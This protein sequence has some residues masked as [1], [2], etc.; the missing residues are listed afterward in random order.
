[1]FFQGAGVCH[2]TLAPYEALLLRNKDAFKK[3][4]VVRDILVEI[5]AKSENTLRERREILKR[6]TEFSDYSV[7]WENDQ[8]AARGLVSQI[9]ELINVKD[10]FTRLDIERKKERQ[11]KIEVAERIAK[12]QET[13]KQALEEIKKDF[14]A[15]FAEQNPWKRGKSIENVL[16]RYFAWSNILISEA[17]TI[18]GNENQGIVEQIDGVIRLR[19]QP[20]LV[21]VKW[22]QESLGRD[23][24]SSHL[25]R[26]FTRSLA[27]GIVISY[28][29]YSDAVI[30]D[31]R[32]AIVKGKAIA[33]CRLEDFV[34]I[35]DNGD[36]LEDYFD[37]KINAAIIHKNPYMKL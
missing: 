17:I 21:E 14:Y 26:I 30:S 15:L 16:N 31:C 1:M 25:V 27:G 8:H 10:T 33:L 11:E 32:D 7:C 3:H 28:S 34:R 4:D 12:Q 37:K 20:F 5:N 24:V 18:K 22:E 19:E 35:V 6:V 23:K 9:R 13:K 2:Q 29:D 36:S